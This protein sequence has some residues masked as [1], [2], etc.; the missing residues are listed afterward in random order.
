[1]PARRQPAIPRMPRV[2]M[3]VAQQARPRPRWARRVL[4]AALPAVPRQGAPRRALPTTGAARRREQADLHPRRPWAEA[5]VP[6]AQA[7]PR[8]P[9][10]E[11]VEEERP[12]AAEAAARRL[13]EVPQG[14]QASSAHP[15]QAQVRRRQAARLYRRLEQPAERAPQVRRGHPIRETAAMTGGRPRSMSERC[16]FRACSPTALPMRVPALPN[17]KWAV[18]REPEERPAGPSSGRRPAAAAPEPPS[19]PPNRDGQGRREGPTLRRRAAAAAP[20]G[21]AGWQST[22][23]AATP[24]GPRS[25]SSCPWFGYGEPAGTGCPRKG[26]RRPGLFLR[27]RSASG[28]GPPYWRNRRKVGRAKYAIRLTRFQ[29]IHGHVSLDQQPA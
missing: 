3:K 20:L 28:G 2:A 5:Q 21:Q 4:R 14:P 16:L 8:R 13:L 18:R 23:A 9:A 19:K 26:P 17:P 29:R 1:M 7:G 24:A 25:C 15:M 6:A 12:R 27:T 22:S 10:A 11:A